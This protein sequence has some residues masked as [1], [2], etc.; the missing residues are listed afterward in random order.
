MADA[1]RHYAIRVLAAAAVIF[2]LFVAV[3]ELRG[4]DR[5]DRVISQ[6]LVADTGQLPALIKEIDA[7]LGRSRHKLDRIANDPNSSPKHRLNAG[8]ALLPFEKAHDDYLFERLLGAEPNELVVF[9]ERVRSR[10]AGFVDRLWGVAS[11]KSTDR[12]SKL[13]AACVLAKLDPGDARWTM[14][15]ADIAGSLVLDEN[16]YHLERWLD[17]LRPMHHSLGTGSCDL[18]RPRGPT[19]CASKRP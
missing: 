1:T 17:A 6:L 5:A 14:L 9:G 4:R 8:L 11:D 10:R 3:M 19:K 18:P 16:A 15:A 7:D 2:L 12:K 13:R